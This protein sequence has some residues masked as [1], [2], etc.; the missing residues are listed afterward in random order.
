MTTRSARV[1]P[2]TGK[3]RRYLRALAHDQKPLVQIGH[4]GLTDGVLKAVDAALTTHELLKV[5][6]LKECPEDASDV[7]PRLE[8]DTRSQVAQHIGRTL[9]VYRRR[10]K[11]PKITLPDAAA[12]TKS[13]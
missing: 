13:K 4:E 11:D 3:Q 1:P 8:K 6:L 9:L 10:A 7:I 2:L 12:G 5:K